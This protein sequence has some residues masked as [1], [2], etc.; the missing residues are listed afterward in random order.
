MFR[1][2]LS[3]LLV[4]SLYCVE[5]AAQSENRL[6]LV[7][8]PQAAPTAKSSI[9]L[10]PDGTDII[11]G[12]AAVVLMRQP[13]NEEPYVNALMKDLNALLE[14]QPGDPKLDKLFSFYPFEEGI[15]RAARMRDANWEYPLHEVPLD[16][17][18]LQELPRLGISIVGQGLYLRIGWQIH[19]REYG[20][21]LENIKAQLACAR[22]IGQTPFLAV[23][24]IE[25]VSCKLAMKRLEMWCTSKDTANLYW[26]LSMLPEPLIDTRLSWDWEAKLVPNSLTSLAKP[27]WLERGS[28]DWKGVAK[29][30]SKLMVD[31]ME[32]PM[33]KNDAFKLQEKLEA[34]SKIELVSKYGFDE[35]SL[36]KM[37][38]E[39]LAMR[40]VI[41]DIESVNSDILAY[42]SME[43]KY[44]IPKL[45]DIEQRIATQKAELGL[46]RT[47]HIENVLHFYLLPYNITRH[48]RELQI[49]ESIRHHLTTHSG[50]LPNSLDELELPA[51]MD[52]LTNKSFEYEVKDEIAILKTPDMGLRDSATVQSLGIV[53]M[54]QHIKAISREYEISVAH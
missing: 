27:N 43:P 19:A 29:S 53:G 42:V 18:Y 32:R 7:I 46:P 6:K 16:S 39:E 1:I 51:P 4:G 20:Q 2:L 54:E 48:V 11:E 40:W 3:L 44:A 12:N 25:N 23:Q 45:M 13:Y 35:E 24:S 15:R 17:I 47:L 33:S 26:A 21:A 49:V 31:Q 38:G 8:Y 52:P 37:S 5:C 36:T 9:R 22:H 41:K 34:I 10:L 14:L 30:F 50:K 28:S